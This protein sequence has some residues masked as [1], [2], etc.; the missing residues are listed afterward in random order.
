MSIEKRFDEQI[1]ASRVLD[2]APWL[3]YSPNDMRDVLAQSVSLDRT[4][5]QLVNFG[6]YVSRNL[7]SRAFNLRVTPEIRIDPFPQPMELVPDELA[8]LS[9]DFFRDADESLVDQDGYSSK[10]VI[11]EIKKRSSK[12]L[13]EMSTVAQDRQF[14]VDL[15]ARGKMSV[16]ENVPDIGPEIEFPDFPY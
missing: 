3:V 7:P 2:E 5:G 6:Q 16:D 4:T 9:V 15:I 10:Q 11:D 12:G 8:Q 13:E 14:I 1:A